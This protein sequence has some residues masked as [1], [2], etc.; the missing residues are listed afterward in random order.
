MIRPIGALLVLIALS[1]LSLTVMARGAR[2]VPQKPVLTP[3]PAAKVLTAPRLRT[4][5]FMVEADAKID[6]KMV[7]PADPDI[8]PEM[9]S[10]LQ[11]R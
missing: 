6:P 1:S 8:D 5:R 9:V 7:V 3:K 4:D 11:P 10:K 2:R